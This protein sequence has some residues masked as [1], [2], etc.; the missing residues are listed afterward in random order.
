MM[1]PMTLRLI[2]LTTLVLALSVGCG[3][4][5]TASEEPQPAA[6]EEPAGGGEDVEQTE[7][8]LLST[9]ECEQQGGTVVGDI[10]DGATMRPDYVCP[11]GGQPLGNVPLGI[12]GSVC[13]PQ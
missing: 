8:P 4:G 9:E 13:C 11:S 3:G 2:S 10:G 12:E 7:R 5:S 1:R 6:T